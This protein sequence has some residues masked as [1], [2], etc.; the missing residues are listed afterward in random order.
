MKDKNNNNTKSTFSKLFEPIF[1]LK[2][3]DIVGE[4]DL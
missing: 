1:E 2:F 4:C 3:L